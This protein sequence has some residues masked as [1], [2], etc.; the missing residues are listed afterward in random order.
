MG[1]CKDCKWWVDV[2]EYDDWGTRGNCELTQRNVDTRGEAHPESLAHSMGTGASSYGALVT[3][4][5]FGCVQFE[6]KEAS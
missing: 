3:A 2:Y 6:P 5:D 1:H 4:P